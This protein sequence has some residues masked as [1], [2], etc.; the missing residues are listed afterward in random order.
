MIQLVIGYDLNLPIEID[1]VSLFNDIKLSFDIPFVKLKDPNTKEIVYK[2]YKNITKFKND[3]YVISKNLLIN[4]INTNTYEFSNEVFIPIKG[5]PKSIN[6]K[7]KLLE[8]LGTS[9]NIGTVI[10]KNYLEDNLVSLDLQCENFIT[11][12]LE[13]I[14]DKKS[15]YEI[16]EVVQ[17][18]DYETVY[19]DLEISKKG[20]IELKVN[21]INT[22]YVINNDI[23]FRIIEKLNNFI[24]ILKNIEYFKTYTNIIL[25]LDNALYKLNSNFYNSEISYNNL[26]LNVGINNSIIL[27]Y[28]TIKD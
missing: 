22:S 8:L 27:E 15:D 12:Y 21:Y 4:W 6:Y 10:K 18:Y 19:G 3:K 23:T 17:F 28:D 13:Q 26:L 2:I 1:I 11:V 7:L 24:D 25:P 16:N 20:I 14:K 5:L 9:E